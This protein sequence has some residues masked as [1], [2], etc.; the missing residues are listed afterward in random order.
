VYTDVNSVIIVKLVIKFYGI[1][2]GH[3]ELTDGFMSFGS[4]ILLVCFL[5]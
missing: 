1:F 2:S 5:E 4:E 3:G